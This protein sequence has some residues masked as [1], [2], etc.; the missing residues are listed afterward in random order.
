[1]DKERTLHEQIEDQYEQ[2][3]QFYDALITNQTSSD[4]LP[5]TVYR[6]IFVANPT[7]K[8]ILHEMIRLYYHELSFVIGD[9]YL[10][11]YNEG[12]RA[13]IKEILNR[14]SM[15]DINDNKEE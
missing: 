10:T 5:N 6:S 2:V 8:K 11:A 1:M 14:I 12:R 7:G 13:V 3:K 15:V 9:P 4:L